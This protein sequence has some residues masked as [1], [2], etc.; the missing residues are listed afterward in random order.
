[1]AK[2]N[3]VGILLIT[4]SK[5]ISR[6]LEKIL[7]DSGEFYIS[8]VLSGLDSYDIAS[9]KNSTAGAVIVDTVIFEHAVQR[10]GYS[11]ISEY[12]DAAVIAITGTHLDEASAR[13]YDDVVSLYDDAP[14]IIGRLRSVLSSRLAHSGTAENELSSREK[15]I[16]TC[17]AKGLLNKEIADLHNISIHTVITHRKNITRKTGIKTVA[18]LTVY[19]LLNNLIDM[20]SI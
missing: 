2:D 16:L 15:E 10:K 5:I 9:L 20:G 11:R 7:S 4:P 17:V 19:A 13:S 12:T 3:R 18:G 6:G 1:M 14:S 8:E